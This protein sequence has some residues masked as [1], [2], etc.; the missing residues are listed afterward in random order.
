MQGLDSDLLLDLYSCAHEPE[1]WGR[2]MD[3]LC[4]RMGVGSSVVQILQPKGA[5]MVPVW[6]ARDSASMRAAALHDRFVNNSSNP[7]FEMKS[8]A[9]LAPSRLI[10]DGDWFEPGCPRYTE[11]RQK[12]G[13][14]GLGQS[15]AFG[16]KC[17]DDGVFSMILHRS[18]QDDRDF[19]SEQEQFLL[20]LGPHLEKTLELSQRVESQT[21]RTAGLES[22]LEALRAGALICRADRTIAWWNASA[23]RIVQQSA[24][25][26][27]QDGILRARR[28]VEDRMLQDLVCRGAESAAPGGVLVLGS[29]QPDEVQILALP[30]SAFASGPLTPSETAGQ[31]GLILARP[32]DAPVLGADDVARLFGLTAAEARVAAALC[33]GSSVKDY[34]VSRGLAEGSARNQLKQALAKTG[35]GRQSDLVRTLCTS[36]LG[37]ANK[38]VHPVGPSRGRRH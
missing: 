2:V 22:L 4:Q 23:E 17:G 25:L 28:H 35:A 6:S 15:I 1:R 30:P 31:I 3:R 12:L 27:L 10:R 26:V 18:A 16:L 5:V 13:N 37:W 38:P 19:D 9:R 32:H 8:H 11:L 34:A 21:N 29:G 14:A 24:H 36:V 7:R 20:E 33:A